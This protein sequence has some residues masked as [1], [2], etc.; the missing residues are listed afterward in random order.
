MTQAR[1]PTVS[2]RKANGQHGQKLGNRGAGL[3]GSPAL[4]PARALPGRSGVRLAGRQPLVLGPRL[5]KQ[6]QQVLPGHLEGVRHCQAAVVVADSLE[7]G[8]VVGG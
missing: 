3:L 5:V 1:L 7:V 6:Q 8:L 4:A 2:V